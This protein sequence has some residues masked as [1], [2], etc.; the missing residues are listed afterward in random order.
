MVRD[1]LPHAEGLPS[2]VAVGL[3][4]GLQDDL[5]GVAVGRKRTRRRILC[6]GCEAGDG[7]ATNERKAEVQTPE[8]DWENWG[9]GGWQCL[10]PLG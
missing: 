8:D 9:N 5:R 6:C 10:P 3:A 7:G 1:R 2:G 4:A